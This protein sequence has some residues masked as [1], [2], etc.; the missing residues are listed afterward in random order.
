MISS[1]SKNIMKDNNEYL[2]IFY[3]L[4]W[5]FSKLINYS[6]NMCWNGQGITVITW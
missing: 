2:G 6:T 1:K 3:L 5:F 4:K